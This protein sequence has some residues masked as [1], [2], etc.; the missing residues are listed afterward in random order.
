MNINYYGFSSQSGY[1]ESAH[2]YCHALK[3][4]NC[5]INVIN[6]NNN[7][8]YKNP[9]DKFD[10]IDI[11]IYHCIPFMQNNFRYK[12]KGLKS[13]GFYIFEGSEAPNEWISI[14]NNNDL[15]IT[16]SKFNYNQIYNKINKPVV[17]IPHIAK[18]EVLEP[19]KPPESIG[20]TFLTVAQHKERKGLESLIMA[21]KNINANLIIKTDNKNKLLNL[22]N[23]N[24]INN[25]KIIDN[26]LESLE[27]L[28]KSCHCLISVSK[29]EGF[30]MPVMHALNYK[31][32]VLNCNYGGSSDFS[33]INNST[34]LN[35][36]LKFYK[37]MDNIPQFRDQFW[38]EIKIEEIINK[39]NYIINNYDKC[40][41]KAKLG[42]NL[43]LSYENIGKIFRGK[44]ENLLNK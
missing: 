36:E 20:F 16:A 32:P 18:K 37:E 25:I 15:I 19:Y 6:I 14:L 12:K 27:S 17:I 35:Y 23:I 40:I 34:L 41:N 8:F 4:N 1:G 11:D 13:V 2:D 21:F 38:A 29:G 43:D 30:N 7:I 31:V 42:L 26:D 22:I 3:N 9:K 10:L 39:I 5:N 28:I 33:D 44:L 24:K